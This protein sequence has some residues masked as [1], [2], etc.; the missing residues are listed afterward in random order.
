MTEESAPKLKVR[1]LITSDSL[2]P[3]EISEGV[4]LYPTR[5]WFKGQPVCPGASKTYEHNGWV[6]AA[7][8]SGVAVSAENLTEKL[9]QSIDVS[10]MLEFKSAHQKVEFELSIVVHV[11]ASAPAVSLSPYQVRVLASLNAD[12]D[13]DIYPG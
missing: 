6:L 9:L 12:I 3:D 8:G 1:L 13:I 2:T 4:G 7:E 10:K 5:H 11:S